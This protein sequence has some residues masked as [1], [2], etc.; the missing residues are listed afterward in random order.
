MKDDPV[1]DE[2]RRAREEVAARFGYDL[3]KYLSHLSEQERKH[4]A[5]VVGLEEWKRR[6]AAVRA[7]A[8]Q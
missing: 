5:R 4:S 6:R 2:V 7:S 8:A 3:R 1:V